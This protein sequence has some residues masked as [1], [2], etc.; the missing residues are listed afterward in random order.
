MCEVAGHIRF[1][2]SSI[3][4]LLVSAADP[5][6]I[7]PSTR[8]MERGG[9]DANWTCGGFLQGKIAGRQTR[10]RRYHMRRPTITMHSAGD[11]RFVGRETHPPGALLGIE[12]RPTTF[13][14]SPAM[15]LPRVRFTVRRMMVAVAVAGIATGAIIQAWPSTRPILRDTR[16]GDASY[17]RA[18]WPERSGVPALQ[19][20]AGLWESTK[21]YYMDPVSWVARRRRTGSMSRPR[22]DKSQ[23]RPAQ[24]PSLALQEG[25]RAKPSVPAVR[26]HRGVGLEREMPPRSPRSPLAS[27]A[28]RRTPSTRR[29]ARVTGPPCPVS[30]AVHGETDGC[31]GGRGGTP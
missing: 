11:R 14:V 13:R 9:L 28:P 31:C 21:A 26:P 1:E 10:R 27:A 25:G 6:I 12:H 2:L 20:I 24:G 3:L 8:D 16:V 4:R 18:R 22:V 15:P 5:P 30:R 7:S 29:G 19:S 17:P 23:S